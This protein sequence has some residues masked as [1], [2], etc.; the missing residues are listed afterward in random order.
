MAEKQIWPHGPHCPH[1]GSLNVQCNVRHKTMTHRCRDCDNRPQF[2]LKTGTVMA[3]SN[4]GYRDWAIAI[5]LLTTNLK[6]ISAMKLHQEL[7]IT[8]TSEWHLA[9]RLRTAFADGEMPK[10]HGPLEIDE[11]YIGGERKNMPKAKRKELMGRGA[12][13]KTAVVGIKDRESNK[14]LAQKVANTD[15][16]TLHGI[17]EGTTD[18]TAQVYLDDAKAY[19]GI[20]RAHESVNHSAGE[21]GWG[22][23]QKNRIESFLSTLKCGY[24]GTFHHFSEEHLDRYVTE[25]DGRHNIRDADTE[26]QMGIVARQSKGKRALYRELVA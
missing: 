17:V 25:F 7:K 18:E 24:Q 1:C 9:H 4:L 23:A 12:V 3:A 21:Y 14:V 6:G 19:I 15:A 20:D 22:M 2:S 16:P 11:A 10:M 13:G 8:F 26:D 5:S